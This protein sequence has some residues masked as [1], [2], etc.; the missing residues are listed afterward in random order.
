MSIYPTYQRAIAGALV[1]MLSACGGSST[2]S[3]DHQH[4]RHQHDWRSV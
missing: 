3:T 4:H 2:T 1:T